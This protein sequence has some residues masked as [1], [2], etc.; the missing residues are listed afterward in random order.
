[1]NRGLKALLFGVASI[2]LAVGI[3]VGFVG[4]SVASPPFRSAPA[5]AAPAF[6]DEAAL[7]ALYRQVT[8]AV[9]TV[10]VTQR[11]QPGLPLREG[12]GS[13]FLID[14]EG[15][16]VTNNHVVAGAGRVEV[17]L[18]DET[19]LPATVLATA[20]ADDIA[21]IQVDA[22]QVSGIEPL[23]L[24]DSDAVQPGQIAIAV[25]SPFG[26]SGTITVGIVSGVNRSLPSAVRRPIAGMIQTDAIVNPGNSGGPL[27]NSRGEVI[28]ITTALER[29]PV[30][31]RG[32]GLAVPI[33][34]FKT[35]LPRLIEGR[36]VLRPWIGIS[37]TALTPRLSG[38]LGIDREAKGVYIIQVA[39]GS[40]AADAGLKGS[41][42]DDTGQPRKGGDIILAVEGRTVKNIEE[43][44][45]YL[46]TRDAGE[47]VTL[48][49]Q[50]GTDTLQIPLT[51][52]PWPENPAPLE[53]PGQR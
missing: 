22:K 41:D 25:G 13:G 14:R 9:V 5:V 8:P 45:R 23:P 40:P 36:S 19:V 50:R 12:T 42:L 43:L 2:A 21:L 18:S 48:T 1:M 20:P 11:R 34:T 49:V 53:P 6:L 51:L 39:S 29:D 4:A 37:G 30:S 26:L 31:S 44:I 3:G 27:L 28:G 16:I 35:M 46:N 7:I 33:T 17:T 10:S 32:V 38:D 24:G 52:A 15:H 47:K